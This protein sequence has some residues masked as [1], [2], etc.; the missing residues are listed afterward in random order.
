MDAEADHSGGPKAKEQFMKKVLLMALA[1]LAAAL[2]IPTAFAGNGPANK[3]TGD[4]W[5]GNLSDAPAHFVF[6]AQDFGATGDKGSVSFD[7]PVWGSFTG[8]V[9]NADVDVLN[10]KATFTAKVTSSTY[11]WL[12]TNDTITWT[13]YDGGEGANAT[14]ADSFTYDGSIHL[15][16]TDPVGT[17]P[18]HY[19][20]TAGNIQI[21]S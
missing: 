9:I 19:P 13:V 5:Y 2:V 20:A 16:V 15:G 11:Q 4:F 21:H 7:D 6:N 1:A 14:E 18:T 12:N 3:A 8:N 10:Q 17:G